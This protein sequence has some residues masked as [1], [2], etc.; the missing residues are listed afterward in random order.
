M[1]RFDSKLV[2]CGIL[3]GDDLKY[4]E[5]AV[6]SALPYFYT[7]M[8]YTGS[9]PEECIAASHHWNYQPD[10]IHYYDKP[11][12]KFAEARNALHTIC[13]SWWIFHLDDDERIV[14]EDPDLFVHCM[15]K[16][17]NDTDAGGMSLNI[18]SPYSD[19]GGMDVINKFVESRMSRVV[20]C[21]I[22]W[23]GAIHEVVDAEITLRNKHIIVVDSSIISLAHLGYDLE[24]PELMKK[25]QRNFKVLKQEIDNTGGKAMDWYHMGRQY[26]SLRH[27]GEARACLRKALELGKIEKITH[28]GMCAIEELLIRILR[29]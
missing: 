10:E 27:F 6:M 16:Y 5:N 8:L 3:V 14:V 15:T 23:S 4:A 24:Y 1:V 11:E 7:V 21:E 20:R 19:I 12:F 9:N 28:N 18:R 29:S 2:K 17:L 13:N 26:I 22:P 25:I